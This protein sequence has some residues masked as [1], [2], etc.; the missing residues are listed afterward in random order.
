[1]TVTL[2]PYRPTDYGIVRRW[3]DD[4]V[5]TGGFPTMTRDEW[6]EASTGWNSTG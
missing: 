3:I 1:M 5:I 2:R 4:P 6:E